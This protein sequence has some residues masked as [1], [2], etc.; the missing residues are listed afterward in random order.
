MDGVRPKQVVFAVSGHLDVLASE[1]RA[2]QRIELEVRCEGSA[3]SRP[4]T[5]LPQYVHHLT[6]EGTVHLRTC[7]FRLRQ[8]VNVFTTWCTTYR[9]NRRSS[10]A[11]DRDL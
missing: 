6:G 5:P 7:A 10:C 9:M 1:D 2:L 4:C 11:T 3:L 8:T